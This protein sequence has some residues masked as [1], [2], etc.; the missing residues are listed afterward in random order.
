MKKIIKNSI[1][2]L[3]TLTAISAQAAAIKG[4]TGSF[5]PGNQ[6]VQ[7]L[8]GS[9]VERIFIAAEGI[10]NDGFIN[11]YAD[12]VKVQRIGV[13]GYDPDYTF[14]IRR[15][16]QEVKLTFEGTC[17]RIFDFKLFTPQTQ[18][19]KKRYNKQEA[20]ETSWGDVVLDLINEADD[21]SVNGELKIDELYKRVLKPLKKIAMYTRASEHSRHMR[22]LIKTQRA[23]EMAKIIRDNRTF[24]FEELDRSNREFLVADLLSILEDILEHTDVKQNEIQEAIDM[25]KADLEA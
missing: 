7:N 24:L 5:C 25:I 6:V 23:L 3:A 2:G 20:L 15:N 19:T 12:G 10:R 22:S 16:V 1:I 8:N 17:S 9:Y 4:D 18:E 14:R 21:A 11:V 13:P